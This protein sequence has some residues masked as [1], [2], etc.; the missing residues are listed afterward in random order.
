MIVVSKKQIMNMDQQIIQKAVE[1]AYQMMLD[2]NYNMPDRMH[3]A[4]GDN[5]LLLMPCFSGRY[6]ATKLVSVFPEAHQFDAPS[7]NGVVVLND[8]QTGAPLALFDGASLTAQRTGAVGGL[9]IRM[10]APDNIAAAGVLGAGVQ[11]YQQARYL[12]FNRRVKHLFIYD[13]NKES[14]VLTADRLKQEFDLKEISIC[15]SAIEL[16]ERSDAVIAATTSKTPLFDATPEQLRGKL[17]VSIGSFQPDMQEF[18]DAL[19][20][21]ADRIFVDTLFAS[22]E[23][24]DIAGPLDRKLISRA[25]IAPFSGL[26][27][28]P[29]TQ[30]GTYFFK[31]VGMALFDLAVATAIYETALSDKTFKEIE[32]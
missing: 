7:V 8:N 17:F 23:S 15:P 4:D 27:Q 32:I 22:K 25:D 10:L 28:Q 19:S 12:L 18:P 31:S 3:V 6:F 5:M 29:V 13:L 21:T 9:A 14:A 26:L 16:V 24:G 1:A 20:R 30:K 2:E 11:G